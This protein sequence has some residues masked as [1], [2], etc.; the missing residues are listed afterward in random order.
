MAAEAFAQAAAKH[1]DNLELRYQQ[2]DALVRAGNTGAAEAARKAIQT[3]FEPRLAKD[4]KDMAAASVLAQLY[5][6]LGDQPALDRLLERYP[7][8]AVGIG[9]RHAAEKNWE[10][11]VAA[12]SKAITPETTD[13]KLLAKRA[14]AYEKQ[15]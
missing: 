6:L 15:K 2:I 8:A 5:H 13:A 7:A 10:R 11:A 1:P 9:D 4:P 12:Y 14:E 3:S